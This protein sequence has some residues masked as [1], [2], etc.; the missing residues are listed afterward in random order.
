VSQSMA[1]LIWPGQPALGQCVK[2]RDEQGPCQ[3]V[4][5]IAEDIKRE[6]LR[7]EPG[8]LYYVPL[9]Q[10]PLTITGMLV[11]T[12]APAAV[13][14]EPLRRALQAEM[15]GTSYLN[16]TPLTEMVA[17]EMRSWR[18]GATLFAVFGALALLVASIGLYS[19]IAFTVAQ[20][21]QEM[22]VRVALGATTRMV[23]RMV[24]G[25]AVRLMALAV[26]LGLA[27]AVLASRWVEPLLFHTSPRDPVV[28][29]GVALVLV[30]VGVAASLAPALRAAHTDPVSALRSD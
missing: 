18:L 10:V 1:R 12:T 20:R 16:A 24:V 23:V 11:R 26:G 30:L 6:S 5:G 17:P 9:E 29:G 4:V 27:A 2:V 19:V 13:S 25:D 28:L 7:D 3:Y 15:P 21:R 22:G 8:L 14:A